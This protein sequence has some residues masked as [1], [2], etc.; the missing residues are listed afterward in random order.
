MDMLVY[1]VGQ[2]IITTLVLWVT[3]AVFHKRVIKAELD[4]KLAEIQEIA[5]GI[6]ERV[7]HGVRKALKGIPEETL[8]NTTKSMIKIGS[9]LAESGLGNL[10][11]DSIKRRNRQDE[12]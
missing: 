1:W 7:A 6:E 11:A 8:R 5:D 9:E 12:D 10:F 3:L 2:A 4:A